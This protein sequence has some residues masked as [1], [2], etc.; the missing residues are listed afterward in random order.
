MRP[1]LGI[2]SSAYIHVNVLHRLR[3]LGIV[4]FSQNSAESVRS[5]GRPAS[6]TITGSGQGIAIVTDV[7]MRG[8]IFQ[9]R[10]QSEARQEPI[11]NRSLD[12]LK[13]IIFS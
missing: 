12:L 11:I 8:W 6:S 4:K 9:S 1:R 3:T 7:Q 5:S 2:E 10:T 13:A